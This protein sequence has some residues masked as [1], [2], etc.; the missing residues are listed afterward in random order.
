MWERSKYIIETTKGRITIRPHKPASVVDVR[1]S[2]SKKSE[3]NAMWKS[4]WNS[5]NLK[6]IQNVKAE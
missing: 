3:N 2:K 6:R 4:S 5:G 1:T